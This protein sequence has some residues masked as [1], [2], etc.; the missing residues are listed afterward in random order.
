MTPLRHAINI[1]QG[2]AVKFAAIQVAW[3]L[4]RVISTVHS[5]IR[6]GF[7]TAR[8]ILA[9]FRKCGLIRLRDEDTYL[10]EVVGVALACAGFYFQ[11]TMKWVR[12]SVRFCVIVVMLWYI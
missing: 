8:G 10:D 6:G 3:A 9:Y 4:Q 7:M 11:T 2:F 1:T 12:A 5:A